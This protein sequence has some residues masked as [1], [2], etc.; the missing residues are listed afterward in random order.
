MT[1]VETLEDD[2]WVDRYLRVRN[3]FFAPMCRAS[4]CCCCCCCWRA[5][6]GVT[7]VAYIQCSSLK[8]TLWVAG[9]DVRFGGSSGGFYV[10][11]WLISCTVR[12]MGRRGSDVTAIES[13]MMY[14]NVCVCVCVCVCLCVCWDCPLLNGECHQVCIKDPYIP[15]LNCSCAPGY[16]VNYK[17]GTCRGEMY[18][19][20]CRYLQDYL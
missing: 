10:A 18:A 9:S 20:M 15:V 6:Q 11:K 14:G 5:H 1:R 12:C 13:C 19:A 2:I 4:A 3:K 8:K 17:G 16:H 7:F